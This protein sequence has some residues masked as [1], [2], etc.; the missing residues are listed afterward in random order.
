MQEKEASTAMMKQQ[1]MYPKEVKVKTLKEG[2]ESVHEAEK[3]ASILS[4]KEVF[5]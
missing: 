4:R 5:T 1:S 3:E 2:K